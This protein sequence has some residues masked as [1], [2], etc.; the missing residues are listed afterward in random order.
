MEKIWLFFV[1]MVV[2]FF[3]QLVNTPPMVSMPRDRRGNIQQQHVGDRAAEYAALDGR[4]DGH[5]FVRVDALER[6][7]AGDAFDGILHSRDTGG[8]ADEDDLADVIRGG[9][10]CVLDGLQGGA[11][12]LLRR[13]PPSIR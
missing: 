9:Q 2:F 6:V 7:F 11:Y 10:A 12:G 1:G 5:A 3:N 8:A 13:G 4:A